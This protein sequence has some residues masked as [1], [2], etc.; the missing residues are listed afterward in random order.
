[1]K[2]FAKTGLQTTL[3]EL[4]EALSCETKKLA[5]NEEDAC[6]LTAGILNEL[7]IKGRIR[8]YPRARQLRRRKEAISHEP[9]PHRN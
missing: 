8:P 6:I 9:Q 4:I 1:M 2:N 5:G 3:G 7:L